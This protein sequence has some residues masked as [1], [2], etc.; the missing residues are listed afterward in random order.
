MRIRLSVHARVR[1][2]ERGVRLSD[3][4]A[5]INHPD[6]LEPSRVQAGRFL[7]KR[8]YMHEKS[9]RRHLLLVI[10]E[11]HRSTIDVITVID[12]SK[13]TKYL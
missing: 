11:N 7:A 1:M 3:I 13:I 9:G 2:R 4:R 8:M 5:T 12:T 6:R 10:F